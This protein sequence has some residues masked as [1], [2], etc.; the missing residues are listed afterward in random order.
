MAADVTI[1]PATA[2]DTEALGRLATM[3]VRVHHEFDAS[4]FFPPTENTPRG[5]GGFLGRQAEREDAFVLVAEADGKVVGY[6]YAAL[7]G[8]DYM[9][10][11]G[12]AGI[13]HDILVDP[14]HRTGGVG[15]K[16]LEAVM[17]K[18]TAMGAPRIVLHTA[19]RNETAQRL[20]TAAGFRPTML[21][22]TW[23]PPTQT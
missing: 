11:R 19:E 6:A 2:D 12:P 7:E 1:R 8:P 17:T 20:F 3:L 13:L 18:L 23:D 5:Y 22:M 4:R 21:E 15:H 14:D 9:A 10:L 16:L